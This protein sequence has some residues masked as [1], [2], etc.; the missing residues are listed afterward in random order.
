VSDLRT[1]ADFVREGLGV[2]IL[3]LFAVPEGL[4]LKN[5]TVSDADLD[6]PLG[7]A[8]SAIR[9]PSAATRA[10]LALIDAQPR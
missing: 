8:T 6:W 10:L 5:V 4:G 9:S 2:A 3:P 7:V 1:G